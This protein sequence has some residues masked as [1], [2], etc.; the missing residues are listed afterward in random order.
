M[1][2]NRKGQAMTEMLFILPLFVAVAAAGIFV[3]YTSWQ[4]VRV[5]QAANLAARI[6]GQERIGGGRSVQEIERE[7]GV[8]AGDEDPTTTS[9]KVANASGSA[10]TGS[11]Y[12]KF[13]KRVKAMFPY[14]RKSTYVPPPEIGQNVDRVKVIRVIN[15]P[16]IPFFEWKTK[17]TQVKLKGEAYGG[18][19]TFMY[20]LPRWG[21]SNS[22][23]SEWRSLVREGASRVD[24]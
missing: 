23:E 11:V 1:T 17:D 7:N 12:E 21:R 19:D 6:Q 24:D 3:V 13:H 9:G 10:P 14:A 15:L 22:A 2:S 4:N 5:Q 20:G 16:K 8:G 18:E